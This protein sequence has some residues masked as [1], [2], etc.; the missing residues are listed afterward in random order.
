MYLCAVS[1]VQRSKSSEVESFCIVFRQTAR[2]NARRVGR[3]WLSSMWQLSRSLVATTRCV[4]EYFGILA[5]RQ[6]DA[7]EGK[8]QKM[9]HMLH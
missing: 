7:S 4:S 2:I 6:P 5:C 3:V 9:R 1:I 8:S